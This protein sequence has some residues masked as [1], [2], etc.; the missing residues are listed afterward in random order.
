[1]RLSRTPESDQDTQG[2]W[3]KKRI[4]IDRIIEEPAFVGPMKRPVVEVL[5]DAA[6]KYQAALEKRQAE[7]AYTVPCKQCI[8]QVCG[9]YKDNAVLEA[10][11]A[12]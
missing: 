7:C 4:V 12:P 2:A 10:E 8:H 11:T 5:L 9:S 1:M 3:Q 6:L